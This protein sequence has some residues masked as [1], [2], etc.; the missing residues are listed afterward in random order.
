MKTVLFVD[1]DKGF[2]ELCKLV[3]QEEGYRVF[4]AEDGRQALGILAKEIPDVAV[5]DVRMPQQT[6]LDLAEELNAIAPQVP[7]IL[8]TAYDDMCV[9]DR[10]TRF[11]AACVDKNSGFTE[12]SLALIRV[13]LPPKQGDLFRIGLPPRLEGN[14]SATA[15]P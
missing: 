15:I 10:R 13:L 12:L 6:G 14:L 8:Y 3:F 1:D 5:L 7:V 11:V 4:L 2:L 9:N